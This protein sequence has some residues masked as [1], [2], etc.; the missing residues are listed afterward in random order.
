MGKACILLASAI[1]IVLATGPALSA[2]KFKRFPHCPEGAVTQKT[3]ECHAGTSKRFRYC[4]AGDHCDTSTG[5]CQ[6]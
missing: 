3:C 1:A 2:I 5:K 6:K 4:H